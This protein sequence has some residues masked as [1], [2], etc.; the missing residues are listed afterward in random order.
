MFPRVSQT[1][2]NTWL[3]YLNEVLRDYGISSVPRVQMFMAQTGHETDN[4]NTFSEYVNADGTN[5]WCRNYDGGCRYRGRGAIQLTHS[6]NYRKAG[7]ELGVDFVSSPE[8]VANPQYAFKV[9]GLFWRWNNLNQ[10]SDNQDMLTCTRKINGGTNGIDDRRAKYSLAQRCISS[11]GQAVAAADGTFSNSDAYSLSR[12]AACGIVVVA[13]L[14]A[15]IL[16]A[17]SVMLVYKINR[18]KI[19]ETV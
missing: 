18:P 7:S 3:P 8:I 14:L 9:A 5:A 15:V 4:Y 11:V 6:Y 2:V 17:V 10:C 12:G 13:A 19:V 1:N 16:V